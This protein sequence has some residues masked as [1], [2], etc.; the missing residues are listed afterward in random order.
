MQTG[1]TNDY[2]VCTTWRADRPPSWRLSASSAPDYVRY[3][4]CDVKTTWECFDVLARRFGSFGLRDPGLYELHSEASLGKA[5]LR[6][7][8]I[9]PLQ[10]V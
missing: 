6:T 10:E 8:G 7:M 3:G 2:S 4:L 1:D 5:Y 9:K